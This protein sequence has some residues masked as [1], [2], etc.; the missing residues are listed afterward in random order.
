MREEI[1]QY[2]INAL[3][4]HSDDE[5]VTEKILDMLS[6]VVKKCYITVEPRQLFD[7]I[8]SPFIFMPLLEFT[9][10]GGENTK[11]GSEFMRLFCYN[12]FLCEP[13]DAVIDAQEVNV[14]YSYFN[15][16]V[17][18]KAENKLSSA[19]VDGKQYQRRNSLQ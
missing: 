15:V 9:F 1:I 13:Q 10:E 4:H 14:G 2:S 5:F 3:E 6:M 17:E 7:N 11:K 18:T 8:L 16:K 12:L 19:P